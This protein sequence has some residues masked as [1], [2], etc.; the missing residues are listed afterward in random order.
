MAQNRDITAQHNN[1]LVSCKPMQPCMY[2]Q[3][4]VLYT[5]LSSIDPL[6][7]DV[8]FGHFRIRPFGR[9]L[10]GGQQCIAVIERKALIVSLL[11]NASDYSN[12]TTIFVRYKHIDLAM[13]VLLE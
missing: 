9:R 4:Q 12:K 2:Y 6:H 11:T 10:V 7:G 3:L 5:S 8:T 1:H 13:Q